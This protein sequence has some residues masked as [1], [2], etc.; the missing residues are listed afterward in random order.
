MEQPV[1][2]RTSGPAHAAAGDDVVAVVVPHTHWD[3]EWYAPF[4]TMRFHLVRFLDELIDAAERTPDLVFVLD[5]QAVLLE[6]YLEIRTGQRARLAALVAA[7][8]LRPGPCYVQP[9]EF[10]VSGEA[11]VRNLLIGCRVA[12]EFGWNMREGYLPDT[13]GHVHQLPQILQGFGI[14]TF[15]AMRGFGAAA[16]EAGNE[17]W[18]EAPDG[19]R[20]RVTWLR[21]SYSN[22]GVL[23]G[24]PDR[25]PL[26]HGTLVRYDTLHELLD[27]LSA[28]SPSGVLLLLNGGDHMRVQADAPELVRRL[29]AAVGAEVRLGGLEEVHALQAR[30]P[31]PEPVL[32]GELRHGLRH[33]VFDGIGSTRAPMKA[34]N[35]R[36][37]ALVAGVAERLEALAGVLDGQRNADVLRHLWRELVKNYAHDS[38]CGCSVDAVHDEMTM[39]FAKVRQLA[40]AVADDA[41]SRIAR[42][43]APPAGPGEVPIVVVNPSAFTRTAAVEVAVVPD[44]DVP[45]GER[46][47]GWEQR[48]GVEWSRYRLLDAAG[49]PVAFDV[50]ASDA[51]AVVDLL[52][53]RKEVVPDRLRF[54]AHEVPGLATARYRL[55]PIDDPAGADS[56]EDV[57]PADRSG[58]A[59]DPGAAGPHAGGAPPA[60]D[61]PG[62]EAHITDGVLD[63]GVAADGTLS[64]RH[65][66]TGR[67][68]AGLLELLDDADAGDEYSFGPVSGDRPRSSRDAAWTVDRDGDAVVAW[69]TLRLPRGLHP[70]R[71]TRSDDWVDV[72]VALR[73]WI[74]P[75]AGHVDVTIT[76]D[77]RA[78]DHRLRARLHTRLA[79]AESIAESAFGVIRRPVRPTDRVDG[80]RDR[81][82][83]VHALRR[84]VAVADAGGGVQVMTEG[85]H[86]YALDDAGRLDVTLL[87]AVGWLARTDHP[88]RP[89]KIGPE[90]PTPGAQCPGRHTFRLALRP[91]GPTDGAGALYRA[92]E[93]WS[94]PLRAQ[95]VQG[96]ARGPATPAAP[97]GLQVDPPAVV[98]SAFKS[99]EDGHGIVVRVF[100]SGDEPCV[101]SL[102]TRLPVRSASRCDLEERDGSAVPVD[103]DGVLRLPLAT[104]QIATVRLR[105]AAQEDT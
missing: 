61:L 41:L 57:G 9:D 31:D 56:R 90:L 86:E 71:R 81:P 77:N 70:D 20:V 32:R 46:R 103:R 102:T 105:P 89:H 50:A 17:F 2:V 54:V 7:G 18:W 19:S 93:R 51:V 38:I 55:V 67:T 49:R 83:G 84:F 16:E 47:F 79:A 66:R 45:L 3:R 5:G 80:W 53:R 36:T 34:D 94:V 76:I 75:F 33:D 95:A 13:F 43:T 10:H 74:D 68:Y 28:R 59:S 96:A 48:A 92:A 26:H 11:L 39:R 35:E 88:L 42:A 23:S 4:E 27:R 87:R 72:P 15:Y 52:D 82:S 24:D 78:R 60:R 14:E 44:L 30:R 104:G 37:E 91:F 99:A 73:A 21:E 25:M 29:D 64:V 65:R 100:N 40:T 98:L 58:G 8:R 69:S 85:L 101:A 22:A 63:A 6:D 97:L 62:T 12:G 1:T